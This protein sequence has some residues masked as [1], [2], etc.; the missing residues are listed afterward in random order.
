MS[1]LFKNCK[2]QTDN[3]SAIRYLPLTK[4]TQIGFKIHACYLELE[5]ISLR[6]FIQWKVNT[7]DH[8]LHKKINQNF[9]KLINTGYYRSRLSIHFRVLPKKILPIRGIRHAK[10]KMKDVTK[11]FPPEI[12]WR[13]GSWWVMTQRHWDSGPPGT[14]HRFVLPSAVPA[15]LLSC[16]FN[17]SNTPGIK[18]YED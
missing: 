1:S 7:K 11:A 8:I 12:W 18:L 9:L 3:V 13:V 15:L 6:P 5:T 14:C 10:G 4:Q 16:H 17:T 2:K